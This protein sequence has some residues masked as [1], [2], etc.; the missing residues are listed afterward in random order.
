MGKKKVLSFTI[1]AFITGIMLAIQFQTVQ[2]P[3]VRDTRDTKQLRAALEKEKELQAELIKELRSNEEKLSSYETEREQSKEET[4]RKT[5]EE[6]QTEAGLTE[7]KGPG[8]KIYIDKANSLPAGEF[9][10]NYISA[11]LLMRLLNEIKMYGAEHVSVSGH[12]V[13]STAVIREIAGATK[14]NGYTL[15]NWPIEIIAITEDYKSAEKLS[16]RL[17]ASP[18]GDDFFIDH[19]LLTVSDAEREVTVPAYEDKIRI[20]NMETAD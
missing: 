7:A 20:K 17:K 13:I 9:Y 6:L 19:L 18:I 14:I 10:E 2:D 4:L 12:R 1:I 8:L 15:K 11:D 3:V 5:L 16:H